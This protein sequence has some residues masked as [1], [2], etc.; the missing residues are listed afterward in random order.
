MRFLISREK[1]MRAKNYSEL[2]CLHT[3][4]V[5]E[6]YVRVASLSRNS[7][8]REKMNECFITFPPLPNEDIN[9]NRVTITFLTHPV[10]FELISA[11]MI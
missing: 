8:Q 7:Q 10:L 11:E 1:E 3:D 9:D 5:I 6:P 4:F 2:L